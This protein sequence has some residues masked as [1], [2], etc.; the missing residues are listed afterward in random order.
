M[1]LPLVIPRDGQSMETVLSYLTEVRTNIGNLGS[2]DASKVLS[3]YQ[4]WASASAETLGFAFDSDT[5][6]T[7]VLTRRSWLLMETHRIFGEADNGPSIHKTFRAEQTDRLRVF[8]DLITKYRS[9]E[10]R[11]SKS[12]DKFVV[13]D[14]NFFLHHDVIFEHADWE[15]IAGRRTGGKVRVIVPIAVVRELDRQKINGK[16]IKVGK[17]KQD[18]KARARV[19][20]RSMRDMFQNRDRS[21]GLSPVVEIELL[22]DP[23][24]HRP[25]PSVDSEIIERCLAAKRISGKDVALLTRD[26]G[27]KL[28]ATAEGLTVLDQ[29]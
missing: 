26:L 16:N 19:T 5:I 2:G 18:L 1:Q 24:S 20:L 9:I 25:L 4:Q 22:L 10:A 3:E 11:W 7:L 28:T 29:V 13:P 27:M 14:T 12:P 8:D 17:D 15:T 21:Y 23:L 6:E